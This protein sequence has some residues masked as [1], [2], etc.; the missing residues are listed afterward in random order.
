[1]RK[2]LYLLLPL[3]TI[4]AAPSCSDILD[5]SPSGKISLDKVFEDNDRTMF[6]LNTCYKNLPVKGLGYYDSSRGP[7]EW[8]DEA[9]DADET[10]QAVAPTSFIYRGN[11]SASAHPVWGVGKTTIQPHYWTRYFNS[12]WNCGTFLSRIGKAN[13]TD[14]K[15]R[16]RW[17]A[18]AH[19]LRA[20]YYS[21][22]LLW[23]GCPLP[24]SDEPFSL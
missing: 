20:Y 23:F 5:Q 9:W 7:V 11:A 18:E 2:I 16:D 21:E 15:N 4:G 19:L 14:E 22:L 6:F 24:V 13:V 3:L 17:T 1:M 8:S 10:A 12:I